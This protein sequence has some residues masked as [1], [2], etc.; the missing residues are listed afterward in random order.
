[1]L[2]MK[3]I[4][5]LN[6]VKLD[7]LGLDNIQIINETCKLAGIERLTPQNIDDNDEAV[8]QSIKEDTLGIFQWDGSGSYY[9]KRFYLR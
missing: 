2:N 7:I 4:D 8:W 9:I 5:S 3:E 1:M 6:Y